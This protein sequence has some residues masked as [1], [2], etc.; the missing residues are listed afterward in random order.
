MYIY[1]CP[2]KLGKNYSSHSNITDRND[3]ALKKPFSIAPLEK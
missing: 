1:I 3:T 2:T